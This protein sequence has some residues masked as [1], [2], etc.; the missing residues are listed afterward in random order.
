MNDQRPPFLSGIRLRL[1]RILRLSLT[2]VLMLGLLLGMSAPANAYTR[3]N[4]N[5]RPVILIHG[6]DPTGTAGFN[7][8][9]YW[10][11]MRSQLNAQGWQGPIVTLGFYSGDTSCTQY[12]S[13]TATRDTSLNTLGK[14]VANW[15]YNTYSS[16]NIA[17]DVIAHSMGG[18]IIQDAIEGAQEDKSGYP[19]TL[20]VEDVVTM[21][22]P[23][24]GTTMSGLCP[25]TQC[26]QL[27]IGSSFIKNLRNNPQANGGTDWTNIGTERDQW[28]L[29]D[30]AV[31]W[32]DPSHKI[33]YPRSNPRV[34]DHHSI[35]NWNAYSDWDYGW[36]NRGM[37]A[38]NNEWN[39]RSPNYRAF[40]AILRHSD[41]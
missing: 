34:I 30:S 12:A 4:V 35:I 40:R 29:P 28:V 1:S 32:M 36:W 5:T 10:Y 8:A 24:G 18:L 6:L 20:Y 19:R 38:W 21:A 22:T 41:T 27:A 23:H 37:P 15:I 25:N 9:D 7:C 14:Q 33:F 13:R 11:G 3:G 2:P 16:K 17:V 26:Q 39:G 31:N